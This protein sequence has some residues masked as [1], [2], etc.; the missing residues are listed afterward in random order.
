MSK[1]N[2]KIERLEIRLKGVSAERARAAVADLGS[3]LM[4]QLAAE[5][6]LGRGGGGDGRSISIARID[7]GTTGAERAGDMSAAELRRLI[8]RR[9]AASIG[10]RFK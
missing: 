1:Q 3:D 9:I 5:R 10:D 7:S 6:T 8:V 4:K 2:I